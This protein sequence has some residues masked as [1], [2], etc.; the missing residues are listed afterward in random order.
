M[1]SIP[2]FAALVLGLGP[3]S[4]C[5][6]R[7]APTSPLDRDVA[8]TYASQNG[9]EHAGLIP[10]ASFGA[11][12][13]FEVVTVVPG[14]GVL[15]ITFRNDNI[16]V[17]TEERFAGPA[18]VLATG[19]FDAETGE[20]LAVTGTAEYRPTAVS[21]IWQTTIDRAHVN[22]GV[23]H[24]GYLSG[25]GTGELEGLGIRAEVNLHAKASLTPPHLV[26]E[27]AGGPFLTTGKISP[28]D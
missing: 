23:F 5:A 24:R 19:E 16:E 3:L 2:T 9:F 21:G 20:L 10:F 22:N 4:S 17:S 14:D 28:L 26:C 7:E 1:R 8:P 13:Q 11:S 12:C 18:T 6:D 25:T 27:G 15:F